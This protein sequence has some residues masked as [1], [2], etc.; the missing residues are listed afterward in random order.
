MKSQ[1]LC[2]RCLTCLNGIVFIPVSTLPCMWE[3]CRRMRV[4]PQGGDQTNCKRHAPHSPKITGSALYREPTILQYDDAQEPPAEEWRW[5]NFQPLVEFLHLHLV[6]ERKV[7]KKLMKDWMMTL[8]PRPSLPRP[9]MRP[10]PRQTWNDQTF[11]E[12]QGNRWSPS[13]Q[14]ACFQ[15]VVWYMFQ[16]HMLLENLDS[17][18]ASMWTWYNIS[19]MC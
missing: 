4:L 6:R 3:C 19:Y 7:N 16:M 5:S 9:W 8:P 12:N 17:I 18:C 13:L 2:L 14:D 1:N 11:K 10:L 15:I